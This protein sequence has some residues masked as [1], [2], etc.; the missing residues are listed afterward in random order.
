MTDVRIVS[1]SGT[2]ARTRR[3]ILDAAVSVLTA[4]PAASLADIASAA[5]VGRTTVHRYFPERADLIAALSRSAWDQVT[6]AT[7][8]ARVVDGPAAEALDRLC[9]EYFDLGQTLML[10]F[11]D[12][13]Q[14]AAG[15]WETCGSAD[16]AL[17]DLVERGH[18][19][20]S[21][22][23]RLSPLWV[24]SVL[25]SMLYSAWQYTQD[26]SVSRH[27]ALDMCRH[28]LRKAVKP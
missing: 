17:L 23:P 18:Q 15:E 16:Q 11:N 14:Y 3:A 21:I 8:R 6:M 12:P 2:K 28:T 10:V 25:W 7:E 22:D 13:Q 19:D 20:G 27:Q 1:E 24:Q 9:Q 5:G 26:T 4:D